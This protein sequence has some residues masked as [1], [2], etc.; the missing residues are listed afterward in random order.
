MRT[1]IQVQLHSWTTPIT[2][3]EKSGEDSNSGSTTLRPLDVE[4]SAVSG[5]DSNSGSTTL[6]K[7]RLKEVLSRV[8]TPIQVQLH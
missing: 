3:L 2:N 8:R 7:R 5:E 4:L 1:P 6:G